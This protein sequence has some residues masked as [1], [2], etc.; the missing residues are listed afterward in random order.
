MLRRTSVDRVREKR[1]RAVP[2][3]KPRD[4]ANNPVDRN[5]AQAESSYLPPIAKEQADLEG[6]CKASL[7]VALRCGPRLARL[8]LGCLVRDGVDGTFQD[9][10][11]GAGHG[12]HR[13]RPGVPCAVSPMGDV[14]SAPLRTID[15]MRG[16][17]GDGD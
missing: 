7:F 15:G 4:P 13:R 17:R 1:V 10:A 3:S 12:F 8:G 11:V 2:H 6:R 9:V 5:A 16:G 14:T